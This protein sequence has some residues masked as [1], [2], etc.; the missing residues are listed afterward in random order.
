MVNI[1]PL[2]SALTALIP[3]SETKPDKCTKD[4]SYCGF[5]LKQYDGYETKIYKTLGGEP[6]QFTLVDNTAL[7]K[8]A[9]N[10]TFVFESECRKCTS[11]GADENGKCSR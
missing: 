1:E 6:Y 10:G 7:F 4:L 2:I 8:C 9:D 5:T 3:M 11:T